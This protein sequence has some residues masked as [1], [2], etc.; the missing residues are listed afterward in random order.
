MFRSHP[1]VHEIRALAEPTPE[2]WWASCHRPGVSPMRLCDMHSEQIL[3]DVQD[4]GRG[5]YVDPRDR[6]C[7]NCEQ[8]GD[9]QW[10]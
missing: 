6:A 10:A 4:F 1:G 2:C 3:D 5:T 7:V 9:P 8:D